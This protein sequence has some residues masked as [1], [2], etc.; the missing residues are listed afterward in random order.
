M[1]K[2]LWVLLVG[3]APMVAIAAEKPDWAFPVTDKVQPP[4]APDDKPHTAPGSDKSLTRKQI[5]DLFNP[6]DWY[7]DQ[8]PPLPQV[9][10]HGSGTT[11]RACG[12][13]H[14]PTGTGH[15]ESAYVAALPAAYFIRQMA[16][17]K[18]GARKGSGSMTAI[19]KEISD[20]DVRAAADYFASVKPRPW[21]RVVET[22]TVPK[23]YVG[24][25]NK[26]LQLPGGGDEPIG[27][28]IVEIPEDEEIVLNRDPRS[29][30]IALVPQ[31]SIAKG[32]ALAKG[33]PDGKTVACAICH[34]PSLT[35]LG[36]VPPIGGR[37]ANYVVRQLF[38]FQDGSRA[39]SWAPLM[40]Q[41][42]ANLT[43][44]DML[45]LAAYTA[46]LKP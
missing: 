25:G 11:V 45:A 27:N 41:V 16:D 39:G 1:C 40:A 17:Y 35:G 7:P 38:S 34:G 46:S 43:V 42:V 31:G 5:D 6:P 2:L 10:A 19:G 30:F 32:E 9:V 24:P 8:H 3:L 20:N 29:G 44:D 37:Q 12:S 18:T 36:E 4:I 26:R 14:L 28:R 23:T 15:D 33:G 22:D 13:C 21:I